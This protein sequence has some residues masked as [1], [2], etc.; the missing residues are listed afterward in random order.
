MDSFE[1]NQREVLQGRGASVISFDHQLQLRTPASMS[2]SQDD[3]ECIRVASRP[4]MS[5]K[6]LPVIQSNSYVTHEY[7]K[8]TSLHPDLLKS[9]QKLLG[10]LGAN[11]KFARISQQ[12]VRTCIERRLHTRNASSWTNQQSGCF[13]CRT[14]F[15]RRLPCMRAIGG[16][17]LLL[18]P[19]PVEV[20]HPGATWQ[21]EAYYVHQG[22]ETT[23][24]FPG[25]W[26]KSE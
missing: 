11:D 23:Q 7:G 3:T 20:R 8:L 12:G 9:I 26:K 22:D 25:V 1:H 24:S 4:L 5:I 19:L 15:N 2:A 14:C 6:I 13:A 17:E 18:L 16:H 10:V 21:T